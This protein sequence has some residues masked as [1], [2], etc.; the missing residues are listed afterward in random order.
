M[1]IDSHAHLQDKKFARDLNRVLARAA[2]AGI[3]R[4]IVVGDKLESSRRAIQ[5]ARHEPCLA[6]AVGIHP[7]HEAAF[8]PLALLELERLARDPAVVA[9]GEIGLDFHYP[10]YQRE[11][12]IECFAAQAHLAGRRNLPLIIHCRDAYDDLIDLI[13]TDERIPRRGVVHCFSGDLPQAEELIR[14]GFH[15]GLGGAITYPNGAALRDV[16]SRIGLDRV[17]CETDAPYLPPQSKRGRRNEPS[18]MKHT[19]KMLADLT[20]VSYQD[21]ARITKTNAIRLFDL[22]DAARGAVTYAIRRNLYLS[23]TNR[24]SNECYY[25]Q[26]CQDYMVMGHFLKLD[27]EPTA[28]E[29]LDRVADIHQYDEI[30]LSGLGEPTMRWDV[31]RQVARGLKERGA[32]VGLN[33]NGNGSLINQRDLTP[34]LAG[35]F[36]SVGVNLIAHD[37]ET[38]NRIAHPRDPARSWDAMLDFV[39]SARAVVP[40]V[41]LNLVAV[42]EVDVEAC[43]RLAEDELQVRFRVREWRGNGDAGCAVC[44]PDPGAGAS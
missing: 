24:C 29:L 34:E 33:T 40:D 14:L 9:I 6:A 25:C 21:A 30:V 16:V 22:P 37:R 10:G 36:D 17:L 32:R 39:K 43:R 28:A 15:L 44:A 8:S 11:R 38:Y 4:L 13:R 1:L 26:R 3:E 27:E 12:Q 42:P 7:H 19:V 41:T 18:Y 20:G 35:L 23:I 5:L 2:D 31:C